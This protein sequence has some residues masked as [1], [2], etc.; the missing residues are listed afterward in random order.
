ME[1]ARKS[2]FI[3]AARDESNC[4]TEKTVAQTRYQCRNIREKENNKPQLIF[5]LISNSD[6][7]KTTVW[8]ARLYQVWYL[9]SYLL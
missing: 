9:I 1:K 8:E 4:K 6:F 3:I 2:Y 5:S 7:Q